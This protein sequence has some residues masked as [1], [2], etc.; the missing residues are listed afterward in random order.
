MNYYNVLGVNHSATKDQI[1]R[2]YRKKA[3]ELH[4]DR[5]GGSIAAAEKF[6]KAKDAFDTLSDE[7]KRAKYDAKL[8]E[9]RA[10][11]KRRQEY[12]YKDRGRYNRETYDKFL[13][14][15]HSKPFTPEEIQDLAHLAT[16]TIV[17][18]IMM[19]TKKRK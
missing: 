9:E 10:K 2:A 1:K 18:L 8:A 4:P 15:D 7:G 16:D 14:R 17:D 6:M 13:S 5:N 11:S 12:S 3:L 19:F